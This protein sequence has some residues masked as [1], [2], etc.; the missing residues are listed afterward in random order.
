MNL[1]LK[2]DEIVLNLF[3]VTN[4]GVADQQMSVRSWLLAKDVICI[5]PCYDVMF[6]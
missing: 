6:I 4:D 5:K 2:H 1:R 3:Y